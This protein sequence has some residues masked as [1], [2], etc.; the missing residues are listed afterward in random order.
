MEGLTGLV[1]ETSR[2]EVFE[3]VRVDSNGIEVK[4]LQYAD[5]TLFFC[6]PKHQSI[7]AIKAVLHTFEFLA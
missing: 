2:I 1:R 4:I 3:A 5:D 6:Q 7:K